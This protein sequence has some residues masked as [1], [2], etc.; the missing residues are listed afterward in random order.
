MIPG[1]ALESLTPENI[2]KMKQLIQESKGN[3]EKL[4]D[5]I[6]DQFGLTKGEDFK[7]LPPIILLLYPVAKELKV[8]LKNMMTLE[9]QVMNYLETLGSSIA[10]AETVIKDVTL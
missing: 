1:L 2:E 5:E 4:I 7:G 3:M 9:V 8:F 6:L 10:D